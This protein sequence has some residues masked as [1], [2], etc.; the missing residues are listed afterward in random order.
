MSEEP[1]RPLMEHLESQEF[2]DVVRDLAEKQR[3]NHGHPETLA[4]RIAGLSFTDHA[5][6]A[7]EGSVSAHGE[8]TETLK[9]SHHGTPGYIATRVGILGG[10]VKIRAEF[11]RPADDRE[12]EGYLSDLAIDLSEL[13]WSRKDGGTVLLPGA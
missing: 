12:R 3:L 10:T 4:C 7:E 8:Y 1:E 13:E 6:E 2:E 11:P 5:V 9:C